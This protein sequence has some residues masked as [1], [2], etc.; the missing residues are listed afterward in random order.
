MDLVIRGGTILDGTGTAPRVADVAVKNGRIAAIGK[1]KANGAQIDASG[2]AVAPG[3]IDIHSHSDYTLLVDPRAVSAIT[4]GVTLEVIGN[5]G[6]GCAPIADPQMAAPNIYGFNNEIPLTW[7]KVGEYLDKLAAA[8]PAVNVIKLVPNGQLRRATLGVADRAA[9]P[10]ELGRMKRLLEQGLE[11]GAFGYSTG[12]E[13]PAERGAP[14]EELVELCKVV[15]KRGGLYASHT[16]RR[17]EGAVSAIDEAIRVGEKAGAQ[18]QISHLLP[19][20]TDEREGERSLE[21][22]D[23]ARG[24]GLD[25]AFDMHTRLYGTTFLNTIVPLWAQEDLRRHLSSKDSRRRMRDYKSIV[26]SGGWERVVLLDHPKFPQY[27]RK[28]FGELAR[29]EGRDAYD[30][31]FDI[32]LADLEQ[33]NRAMVIIHAY[34]PDQQALMFSHPL[35]M[36]GS[37]ATTLAPDGPLANSVFHGA[38]SWASWYFHFMVH[39]RKLLTAAQAVQRL[40]QMPARR[41]GLGDRGQIAEGYRADIAVFDAE[42]FQATATTFEPNQLAR[43]MRHVVVNGVLTLRD[44]SLTGSRGGQVIR[45]NH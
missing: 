27:S 32:L 37:D 39:E 23:Q 42:K 34:T 30:I 14:D 45:R 21:L 24:R 15:A 33:P 26:A 28:S 8:K 31:A 13:Y 17:D 36:P 25:I 35:C 12:L 9:T 43:G 7:H 41:L 22:I 40:T 10:D 29:K 5:C 19:R 1:L 11:Q 44:A 2:L 20:K 4:Q 38:Y 16:R 3:F 18:I 6:F